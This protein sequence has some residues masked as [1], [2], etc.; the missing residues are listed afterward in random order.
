MLTDICLP[1]ANR[2][3]SFEKSIRAARDL[4][5]RRPVADRAP[6]E[7]WASEVELVSNDGVWRL[8]LEEGSVEQDGLPAYALTCSI[9]SRRA[10]GRSLAALGRRAFRNPA[11]W[12]ASLENGW[13]WDRRH[14]SR[15]EYTLVV[16]V[17]DRPGAHAAMVVTG[18]YF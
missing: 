15:G 18:A 3:Q 17:S 16:E 11:Y 10:S 7:E 6:L 9:S 13:R 8:R 5:F 1:Y 4:E 12:S 14:A 2:E